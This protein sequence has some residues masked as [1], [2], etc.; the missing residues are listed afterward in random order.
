MKGKYIP[1][2]IYLIA[3]LGVARMCFYEQLYNWDM[4]PYMAIVLGYE[5]SD[6]SIVYSKTLEIA[7]RETPPHY[8]QLLFDTTHI[9]KRQLLGDGQR[10]NQ[11]TSFFKIKPMYT[12]ACYLGYKSGLSLTKS[13][14][15][16]SVI[17]FVALSVLLFFWLASYYPGW[18]AAILCFLIII[19]PPLIEVARLSTPDGMSCFWIAIAFYFLLERKS[20]SWLV[21]SLT[22]AILTRIDTVI[23]AIVILSINTFLLLPNS[24]KG[25]IYVPWYSLVIILWISLCATILVNAQVQNG[26][27]SFYV[28]GWVKLSPLMLVENAI[29]NLKTIQLS[30]LTVVIALSWMICFHR[31]KFRWKQWEI[32][33]WAWIMLMIHLTVRYFLFPHLANR[34]YISTFVMLPVLSLIE[35]RNLRSNTKHNL[36]QSV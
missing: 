8:R 14:V 35:L 4:L 1:M 30:S 12:I 28:N 21:L 27:S 15:M 19:S 16:P 22:L 7:A 25:K 10:F 26:F 20:I 17:F 31:R 36:T 5:E 18:M 3:I 32:V 33:Q 34:F 9:L 2:V 29:Q 24:S 13:T 11:Y 23:M 6:S